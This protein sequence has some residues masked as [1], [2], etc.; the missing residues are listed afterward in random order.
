MMDAS[1]V[2]ILALTAAVGVAME[3][4]RT[5]TECRCRCQTDPLLREFQGLSCAELARVLGIPRGTVM[6][7]LHEARQRLRL[8]LAPLLEEDRTAEVH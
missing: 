2:N 8:R 4:I 5:R 1:F 7:R 3:G 6:S